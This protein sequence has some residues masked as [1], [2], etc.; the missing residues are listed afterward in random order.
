[1]VFF[2]G[3]VQL[4]LGHFEEAAYFITLISNKFLVILSLTLQEWKTESTLEPPNSF[5]HR[6]PVLGIQHLKH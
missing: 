2:M 6:T 1:M 4:P 3:G 5:E